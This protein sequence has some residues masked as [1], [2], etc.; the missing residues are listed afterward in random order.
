MLITF[1]VI[2]CQKFVKFDA[3]HHAAYHLN[4]GYTDRRMAKM[5]IRDRYYT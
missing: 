5:C 3:A 1:A 4:N 2:G